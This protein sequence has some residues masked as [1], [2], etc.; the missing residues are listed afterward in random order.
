MATVRRSS[1]LG[2]AYFYIIAGSCL[3]GACLISGW[4]D[5]QFQMYGVKTEAVVSSTWMAGGSHTATHQLSRY[6]FTAEGQKYQGE[7]GAHLP[8]NRIAIEYLK[9]N[10]FMSREVNT[11]WGSK[12]AYG[13]A[14][15]L[16]LIVAGGI[17]IKREKQSGLSASC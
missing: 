4:N 3:C 13:F 7:A 9:A 16:A 17:L 1:Q 10:P 11:N 5:L 8:G 12:A 6:D 14:G 15:G 2:N